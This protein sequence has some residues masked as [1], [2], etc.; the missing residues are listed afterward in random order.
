MV[1]RVALVVMSLLAAGAVS[2]GVGD[3]SADAAF[4]VRGLVTIVTAPQG[5]ETVVAVDRDDDVQ[6]ADGIVDFAFRLQH[7]R[8]SR[9]AFEGKAAVSVQPHRLTVAAT[10]SLGWVFTVASRDGE[11]P[12]NTSSYTPVPIRGWSRHWGPEIQ[13]DPRDVAS[14][15]FAG[16]CTGADGS[17]CATCQAGG[18][19]AQSCTLEDQGGCWADCTD[20]L[21]ACC[22]LG[23]C[24]CCDSREGG[25]PSGPAPLQGTR[26]RQ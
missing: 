3:V 15:L 9:F 13:R 18:R 1:G 12:P 10:P 7:A 19:G 4:T 23:S 16:I 6:P 5:G 24:R 20:G 22:N 26:E 11:F 21:F 2:L 14:Q 8:E 17:P 25:L